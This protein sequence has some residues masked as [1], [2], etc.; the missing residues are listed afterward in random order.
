MITAWG[1]TTEEVAKLL[2]EK[3]NDPD[4]LSEA[5]LNAANVA[6]EFFNVDDL[7]NNVISILEAV[8]DGKNDQVYRHSRKLESI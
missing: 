2:S 7:A 8:L 4:W 6:K 5:S 1:L 3:L